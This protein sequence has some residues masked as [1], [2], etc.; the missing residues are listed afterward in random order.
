MQTSHTKEALIKW[1]EQEENE[2]A[3]NCVEEIR[4]KYETR[5]NFDKAFAEGY[6]VAEF[7]E[8][9]DGR[10]KSYPWKK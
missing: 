6:T 5:F 10:I 2:E 1:L 7:K 3:L 9:I 4:V 8:E